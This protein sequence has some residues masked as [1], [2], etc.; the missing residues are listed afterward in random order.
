M[1]LLG[2]SL[3]P[4]TQNQKQVLKRVE[5]HALKIIN[6]EIGR[7]ETINTY[8]LLSAKQVTV[9]QSHR[10]MNKIYAALLYH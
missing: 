7:S 10:V 1:P 4:L 8:D 5:H 2:G 3:S 6:L 9:K